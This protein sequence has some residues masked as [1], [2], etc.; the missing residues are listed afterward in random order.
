MLGIAPRARLH[1]DQWPRA[2]D[3]RSRVQSLWRSK[4]I[5]GRGV[6]RTRV[7][8]VGCEL[9]SCGGRAH[10]ERCELEPLRWSV[11]ILA[12]IVNR[13]TGR[14]A[15]RLSTGMPSWKGLLWCLVLVGF[16][17][18]DASGPDS[19]RS[20]QLWIAAT[21]IAASS[22]DTMR[23]GVTLRSGRTYYQTPP[24]SYPWPA[25][26]IVRFETSD[27]A[28]AVVDVG[29]LV[30]L[31]GVGTAI[32][33]ARVDGLSDTS[34]VVSLTPSDSGDSPFGRLGV[35][36]GFSCGLTAMGAAYCWGSSWHGELG[37]NST[38]Q[39]TATLSPVRVRSTHEY[40][41]LDAGT[42]HTCAIRRSGPTDCWGDNGNGKL[43]DGSQTSRS[44]PAT[45]VGARIFREISAGSEHTCALDASGAAFCWGRNHRGQLG[46]TSPSLSSSPVALGGV[47]RFVSISG[48]G[49][50]TCALASDG[51]AYCWGNND[52]G[53]LGNGTSLSSAAPSPV[54]GG[55]R[56]ST[57]SAG[58]RH[59]CGVVQGGDAYCWGSNW[60]YQLGSGNSSS[61]AVPIAVASTGRPPFGQVSAGTEHTCAVAIDGS[62]WCWG[63]NV[64]GLLGNGGPV[65]VT[66]NPNVPDPYT[67]PVPVAVAGGI[68]FQSL[69]VGPSHSCGISLSGAAYCWGANGSGELGMGRL[70]YPVGTDYP[71]DKALSTVPLRVRMLF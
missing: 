28:I 1:N 65:G 54:A 20:E 4:R 2:C 29:G 56:F 22:G 35:G 49:E 62:A 32:L 17:C 8:R 52:F 31:G 12:A 60:S 48:G 51:M 59:T 70:A 36:Q 18:G 43:G 64:S 7:T 58:A 23:L 30:T 42:F 61:S 57:L 15:R 38:R 53:Q 19:A 66:V 67:E 13:K 50:H 46:V 55:R 33:T 45:V 3:E 41:A 40:V 6:L 68:R 21:A 14:S 47:H 37:L 11:D 24:R 5:Q 69:A 25:G 39:Y 44:A 34:S 16:G 9:A 63:R 26:K 10:R 27:S 71:V